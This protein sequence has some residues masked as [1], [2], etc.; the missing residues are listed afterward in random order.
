ME[1]V[2]TK[3]ERLL[4]CYPTTCIS[5]II[6]IALFITVLY[7]ISNENTRNFIEQFE[8]SYKGLDDEK[9]WILGSGNKVEDIIYK[10]GST[11]KHEK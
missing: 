5:F 6:N 7:P 8:S 4:L 1:N 9:K 11:L 2:I 3:E 10:Y